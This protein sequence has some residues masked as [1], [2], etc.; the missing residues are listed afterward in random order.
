MNNNINKINNNDENRESGVKRNIRTNST[1]NFTPS[2]S[3]RLAGSKNKNTINLK[4]KK[5][6]SYKKYI[7]HR[8]SNQK[9]SIQDDFLEDD[10]KV[11]NDFIFPKYI[12]KIS[13]MKEYKIIRIFLMSTIIMISLVTILSIV[14]QLKINS[15]SKE[16]KNIQ[17]DPLY[18]F[19]SLSNS[20][21][22]KEN[23]IELFN[24]NETLEKIK[25]ISDALG[26]TIPQLLY[27]NWEEYELIN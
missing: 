26:L 24:D 12:P 19:D 23:L 9:Y 14:L 13:S 25:K 22:N 20:N 10:E 6:N 17:N 2:G 15:I 16:I 1:P 21:E 3:P 8:S 5:Y 4:D 11:Q 18:N 27:T 7:R